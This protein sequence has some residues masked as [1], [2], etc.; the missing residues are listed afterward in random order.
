MLKKGKT[1]AQKVTPPIDTADWAGWECK[2]KEAKDIAKAFK[3][4]VPHG[5]IKGNGI[6]DIAEMLEQKGVR[7]REKCA[8]QYKKLTGKEAKKRW[9][10]VDCIVGS[11]AAVV[12]EE[13]SN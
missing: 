11:V 2:A 4:V 7:N 12:E 10:T 8:A 3:N 13:D 9:A 5:D 1:K 6:L